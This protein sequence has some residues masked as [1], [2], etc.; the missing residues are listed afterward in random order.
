MP[1]FCQRGIAQEF[2]RISLLWRFAALF[3][4]RQGS[5]SRSACL[6]VIARSQKSLPL[7][8]EKPS[9]AERIFGKRHVQPFW[10]GKNLGGGLDIALR[11]ICFSHPR[12]EYRVHLHDPEIEAGLPA[13]SHERQRFRMPALRHPEPRKDMRY[14][15]ARI[16]M[17][18]RLGSLARLNGHE[19]GTLHLPDF[20]Q[21]IGQKS[22][23]HY[24]RIGG[25]SCALDIEFGSF[26]RK[27]LFVDFDDSL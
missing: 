1:T 19:F 21:G 3:R 26:K 14:I 8:D 7:R 4:K 27:A 22:T 11:K 24:A 13:L 17:I 15:R 25:P 10:L 2:Q 5:L 20:D 9:P 16:K 23:E 12:R 18:G 6:H